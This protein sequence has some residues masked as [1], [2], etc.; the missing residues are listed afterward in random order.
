MARINPAEKV[1]AP[2]CCAMHV[3]RGPSRKEGFNEWWERV[4][5]GATNRTKERHARIIYERMIAIIHAILRAGELR[6]EAQV[7][8]EVGGSYVGDDVSGHM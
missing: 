2:P 3:P 8:D 4:D 6:G 1:S 5:N 7:D